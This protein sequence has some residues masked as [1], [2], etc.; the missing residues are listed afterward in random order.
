MIGVLI[1]NLQMIQIQTIGQKIQDYS[2]KHFRSCYLRFLE[3]NLHLIST[4]VISTTIYLRLKKNQILTILQNL[5]KNKNPSI[6]QK[7]L[8]IFVHHIKKQQPQ[9]KAKD[10][11]SQVMSL[12]SLKRKLLGFILLSRRDSYYLK[13]DIFLPL[14]TFVLSTLNRMIVNLVIQKSIIIFCINF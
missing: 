11:Q 2:M 10:V 14:R 9:P 13:Q 6:L 12:Y 4:R 8:L 3:F 7:I 5:K 1:Q